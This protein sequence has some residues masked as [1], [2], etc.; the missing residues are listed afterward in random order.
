MS[1]SFRARDSLQGHKGNG[2]R[3]KKEKT[4]L[5]GCLHKVIALLNV[6]ANGSA[7]DVFYGKCICQKIYDICWQIENAYRGK[8]VPVL[9]INGQSPEEIIEAVKNRIA[10]DGTI[11]GGARETIIKELKAARAMI[12]G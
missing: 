6:N 3:E 5:I 1:G 12:N 2:H 8:A 4:T 9:V 10:S 7:N 11:S